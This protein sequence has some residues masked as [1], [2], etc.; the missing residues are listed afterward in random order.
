[1]LPEPGYLAAIL[2]AGK[3]TR[4]DPF[5]EHWAKPMLPIVNQ[6]IVE[7]QLGYLRD[8]GLRDVV[9]VV[10]HRKEALQEHFGDGSRL[11][12]RIR[13]VEQRQTLGIAHA[14][15]QLDALIDRPFLLLLGDIFFVPRRLRSLLESYESGGV[16]AVLAVTRER[17]PGVIRKNFTVERD[18]EGRV[19]RVVE[20][21]R[22]PL[23]DL[24]G[25]GVYLFGTEIFD[26][27][28]R[29]PR[30]ALR[31]E[32]E[33]TSA[34]QILIEGGA[35]VRAAEAIDWDFNVT[36]A[37]D[38]LECNLEM[39]RRANAANAVSPTATVH[40][41]A[42]L[43]RAVIGAGALVRHPIE[44]S[45]SLVLPGARVEEEVDLVR[46]IVSREVRVRCGGAPAV[47]GRA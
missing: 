42:R 14:V 26:A 7:H 5:S 27:L 29:T 36:V 45:D 35:L 4:I 13:Y 20:K 30:T 17:D 43:S 41:G 40:P 16:S 39:L 33:L 9:L 44:V 24:K 18:G 21:P 8:L 10:G 47:P 3:G 28:R 1:M 31:D 34:I 46:T 37:A 32:F 15:L 11:G 22:R 2:C 25:C 38:L 12:M 19:V 6:P 23:G